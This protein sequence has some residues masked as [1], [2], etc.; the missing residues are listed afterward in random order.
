MESVAMGTWVR[1]ARR[2][3]QWTQTELAERMNVTKA[4]VSQWE[5]GKTRVS[6]DS[7]LRIKRLTGY[8]LHDVQPAPDWLFPLLPPEFLASLAPEHLES[9]QAGMIAMLTCMHLMPLS[10]EAASR[11]FPRFRG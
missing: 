8:P 4:S 11:R 7:I 10:P 2:H 5:R 6:Y 9:L 3:K 1:E